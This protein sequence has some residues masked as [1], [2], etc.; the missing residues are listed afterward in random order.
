[1]IF[2][3]SAQF[4][5]IQALNPL[6]VTTD[7]QDKPQ[8]KAWSYDGKHWAVLTNSGGTY[9]YRLDSGGQWSSVL[10]IS[11]FRW[12]RAD[13]KPAG[14]LT[15]ILLFSDSTSHLVSLEYDQAARNYKMWSVRPN[16]VPILLDPSVET[17]TI[18]IDSH[19]RMW[20]ASD[21]TNT[22]NVRWS[23]SPYNVWS[24][25][26]N[27]VTGINTDDISGVV[28]IPATNQIGVFW[29]NQNTRRFGFRTHTD[30]TSPGTWSADEVPASQSALNVG[31]GMAD[32]H[33]HLAVSNNGT[34][35]AAV[36]T[37]Y[38][39][40]NHPQLGL[41]VRR[42]NGTWDNMYAVAQN[43][44]RPI[45]ILNE[46][47]DRLKV[48]YTAAESGGN[49]LYKESAVSNIT[50]GPEYM[51]I[52]GNYNFAT[53]VKDTYNSDVVLLASTNT[54]AVSV[55]AT[56][57][58][59][60]SLSVTKSVPSQN[61][62]LKVYPNPISTNAIASFSVPKGEA[63]QLNLHDLKGRLI[64]RLVETKSESGETQT[65]PINGGSLSNGIYLLQLQTSQ[66]TQTSKIVVTK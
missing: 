37:S 52:N 1:M 48:V 23:D 56:D 31:K 25:P 38:N 19:G 45:V 50:F 57:Q 18:D 27:L 61:N 62:F 20:L 5:T 39:S 34:L 54:T 4:K 49:I 10:N 43:G 40:S 63:Y 16:R 47:H 60:Q 53:S 44:T 9:L 6:S 30:G 2:S 11:P 14:N 28:A 41:L 17:A 7:T 13:C 55:L 29:S 46:L 12:G 26:I 8:S 51:L 15:H 58:P 32:D 21:G 22:I 59:R 36:K 33:L 66:S 35:F 42:P 3:A 24:N 65:V 64:T